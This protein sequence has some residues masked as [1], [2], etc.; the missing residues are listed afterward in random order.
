MDLKHDIPKTVSFMTDYD[1]ISK[2]YIFTSFTESH[3][4][5]TSAKE[6]NLANVEKD[7]NTEITNEDKD[8]EENIGDFESGG[9]FIDDDF[10]L[11]LQQES[12]H[13]R[14]QQILIEQEVL[15]H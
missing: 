9:N 1:I 12:E 15:L 11:S 14:Q 4:S 3:I 10:G 7:I 5:A 8:P 6:K 13:I 2:Y